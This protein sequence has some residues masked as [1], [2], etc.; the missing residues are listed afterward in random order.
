MVNSQI[1]S[2]AEVVSSILDTIRIIYILASAAKSVR[3][4]VSKIQPI[5]DV[6]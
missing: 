1:T 5:V 3:T 4:D 2:N 6:A